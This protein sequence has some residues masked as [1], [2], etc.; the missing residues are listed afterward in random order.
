MGWCL[1]EYHYASRGFIDNSGEQTSDI[2]RTSIGGL[3]ACDWEE[4]GLPEEISET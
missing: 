4:V 1:R 2:L 3:E